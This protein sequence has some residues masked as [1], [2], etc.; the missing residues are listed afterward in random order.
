MQAQRILQNTGRIFPTP[1][2]GD[3]ITNSIDAVGFQSE[4]STLEV[5]MTDADALRFIL[6]PRLAAVAAGIKDEA[7]R[8]ALIERCLAET[9]DELRASGQADEN[10]YRSHWTYGEHQKLS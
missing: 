4:Y 3:I 6:V 5:C 9:L 10:G 7:A 8:T 1:P 2:T